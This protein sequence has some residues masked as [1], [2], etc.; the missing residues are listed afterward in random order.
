M[1]RYSDDGM[2]HKNKHKLSVGSV[3]VSLLRIIN[4]FIFGAI[5]ACAVVVFIVPVLIYVVICLLFGLKPSVRIPNPYK[6]LRKRD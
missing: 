6:H 3:F 2:P 4:Q 1:A 5:C